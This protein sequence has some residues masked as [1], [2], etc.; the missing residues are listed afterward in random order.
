M[1]ARLFGRIRP[2]LAAVAVLSL[3]APLGA[4]IGV[5]MGARA[6]GDP[7]SHVLLEQAVFY[8]GAL[9]LESK[10]AA[11]LDALVRE[12]RRRGYPI[13][14]A[15]ISRLEDM[16]TADYLYDDPDNYADFLA[17]EIGC[18]V[19][20]RLL[21]VMPGGFGV[22]YIRHSSRADREL[23][24]GLPPPGG[25]GNLLPATIDAV[26]RLAAAAGVKL[27]VPDVAPPPGG[28][29]Q[30]ATHADVTPAPGSV[31]QP[32]TQPSARPVQTR[33][34]WYTGTWLYALPVVI[35][36]VALALLRPLVIGRARNTESTGGS[37]APRKRDDR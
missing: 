30:P 6:N 37:P 19:R 32:A 3:G 34:A 10:P 36:V 21:I 35:L 15:V 4:P 5:A 17:G 8:G 22:T 11:Q 2:A 9:D 18:C 14:V 25:V 23:V 20:G 7:A 26:R 16:G 28:V 13:S 29:G 31:P 12:S 33:G 27:A 24:D 1:I